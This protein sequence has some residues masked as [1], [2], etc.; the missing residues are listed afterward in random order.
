MVYRA[1]AKTE[2]RKADQRHRIIT[3]AREL[4]ARH[5]FGGVQMT[6]LAQ[7]SGVATGTLYRYFPSKA[8]LY[9]EVFRE[10]SQREVDALKAELDKPGLAMARLSAG[11]SRLIDR[12]LHSRRLA[13]ALI[14]EPVDPKVEADRLEYRREYARVLAAVIRDGIRENAW[15]LQDVER[16][17]AAIVGALAEGISGPLA[18]GEIEPGSPAATQFILHLT[19]FCL[20]ALGAR[21]G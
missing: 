16:S 17:A 18:P 6:E 20:R 11:L 5:G 15:P 12:A 14:A 1:T 13:W 19:T 10:G 9:S 2:A 4:V 21:E 8:S 3:T 7:A